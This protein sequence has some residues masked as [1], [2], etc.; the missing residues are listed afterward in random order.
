[1]VDE[2]TLG[3]VTQRI[4]AAAK[5]SRVV[6]FGSDARGEASPGSDVDLMVVD[7]QGRDPYETMVHLRTVIGP[8]GV[9]VD[10]LVCSSTE[11]ERR[12]LVPGTPFYWARKE[13]R[14]LYEAA[15]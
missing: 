1:M 6:L 14:L 11:Y 3:Q 13:G 8:I 9:G 15:P 12:S 4:V 2:D 7:P 5:P 10:L